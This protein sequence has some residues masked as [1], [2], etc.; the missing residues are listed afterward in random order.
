MSESRRLE[1]V[2]EFPVASR[3]A[4]EDEVNL[5]ELFDALLHAKWAILGISLAAGFLAF[6]I[7]LMMPNI[8]RAEALLAPA[9]ESEGGLAALAGQL[10]GLASLAGVNLK[11]SDTSKVT[12]GLEVL[13]SRL[14]ISDFIDRR[15][16]LIPLIASKEWDVA[17]GELIIDPDI[18]DVQNNRWI[19]AGLRLG[20]SK[21]SEWEAY[22]KFIDILQVTQ[23]KD[24]GMIRIGISHLSPVL[25]KQWV[26]WLV[27][28][29]NDQLRLRDV[30][31]AEKSIQYLK[32]QLTLTPLAGMQQVF[33]QLIEKQT[34]T[35]MLAN[36]RDEYVFKVI[37][38]PVVPEEK[39]SPKRILVAA[40]VFFLSAVFV[41]AIALLRYSMKSKKYQ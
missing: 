16:I 15:N 22:K 17:T 27:A 40:L 38:P 13:K 4:N 18:Y 37:D 19:E 41:A 26:E 23:T 28:D 31:E 24:T 3:S 25:A 11:R 10:G 12:I 20:S 2:S 32:Q 30:N 7:T 21:P 34:Q 14:F 8:Y 5:I 35:V 36:A 29:V 9:E 6:V 33:F 1:A 39:I